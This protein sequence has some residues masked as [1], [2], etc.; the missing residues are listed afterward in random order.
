[1]RLTLMLLHARR[2][3]HRADLPA[4]ALNAPYYAH[5]HTASNLARFESVAVNRVY[6]FTR[7]LQI[8]LALA[9]YFA[10]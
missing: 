4:R 2:K 9:D 10:A 6:Y 5:D 8:V 3:T 1:M 7:L